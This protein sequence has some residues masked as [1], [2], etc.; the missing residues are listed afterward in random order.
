M[1]GPASP[2]LEFS[3]RDIVAD[4][5]AATP[6][7]VARLRVEDG[8]DERVHA[9]VLRCQ[10]RIEPQRRHYGTAEQ[11][12]LRGLFGERE[13]WTDTLRPFQW[14]LCHTT[15]Q[16]F[17]GSTEADL[18]LPCTYDYDVIGSRYLHALGDG[19][20]P[21][22]LLF[23]GTVF[24]RGGA[25]GTGFGVRQVPWDCEARYQLPVAV[26]RQMIAA[27]Y[28]NTG[29]IRLDHDVLARFADFRERRGLISW[30][31]TVTTVLADTR[32]R[33][34]ADEIGSVT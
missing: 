22:S 16:G 2:G 34:A 7:L 19:T 20:V 18:P 1:S 11:D 21:L 4:P 5:Y 32:A 13:R 6:Q 3:V 9:I 12:S 24:T 29:W 27:H 17:T 25:G 28:P 31:E 14:M 8:S 33:D 23:S 26:W 30:D 10:V 15:V